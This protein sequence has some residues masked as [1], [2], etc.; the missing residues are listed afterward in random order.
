[1]LEPNGKWDESRGDM[2]AQIVKPDNKGL[3]HH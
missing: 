1:M 3:F 2:D